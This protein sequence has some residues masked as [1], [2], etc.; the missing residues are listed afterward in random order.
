MCVLQYPLR[1]T[2]RPYELEVVCEQVRMK[3][4]IN[5]LK[6]LRCNIVLSSDSFALPMYLGSFL[7]TRVKQGASKLETKRYGRE[8]KFCFFITKVIK[9]FNAI[10]RWNLI[11]HIVNDLVFIFIYKFTKTFY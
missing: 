8:T 10:F 6:R 11:T 5:I 1:P 7:Q 9:L 2:C 4:L 3:H